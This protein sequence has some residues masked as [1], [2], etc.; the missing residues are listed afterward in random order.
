MKML[1][2]KRKKHLS[3]RRVRKSKKQTKTKTKT[4]KKNKKE[5]NSKKLFFSFVKLIIYNIN[6]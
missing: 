5:K 1:N 3:Q 6:K 4:K 2:L